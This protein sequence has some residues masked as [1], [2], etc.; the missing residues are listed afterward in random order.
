M[1]ISWESRNKTEQLMVTQF[2]T[3][4]PKIIQKIKNGFQKLPIY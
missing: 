2:F 1:Q 4:V 3:W